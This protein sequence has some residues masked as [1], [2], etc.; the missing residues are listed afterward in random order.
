LLAVG[1]QICGALAT[2]GFGFVLRETL[3]ARVSV[4]ARLLLLSLLCSAF[5][6][7]VMVL[8]FRMTK[9][10]AVAASLVRRREPVK[11]PE[12]LGSAQL[13][14]TASSEEDASRNTRS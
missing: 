8:G 9:P 4:P 12:E 7:V 13:A 6:L 14:S 5:Y 1:P 2:A 3:F 11:N 10:L